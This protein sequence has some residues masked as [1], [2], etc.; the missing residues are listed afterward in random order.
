M[1]AFAFQSH[2]F[3][4][5]QAAL[6]AFKN[7][8]PYIDAQAIT[9]LYGLPTISE[10]GLISLTIEKTLANTTFFVNPKFVIIRGSTTIQLAPCD[11][12][13]S[14]YDYTSAGAIW[15]FFFSFTVGLWLVSK[16]AGLILEFIKRH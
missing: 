15:A 9:G 16:N 1:A 8:F 12:P 13:D 7:S 10:S 5:P 4:S 6:I 3:A 11:A 2:C 14:P